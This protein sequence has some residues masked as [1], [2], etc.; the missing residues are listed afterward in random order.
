MSDTTPQIISIPLPGGTLTI[1]AAFVPTVTPAPAPATPK[2]RIGV[3]VPSNEPVSGAAMFQNAALCFGGWYGVNGAQ[4]TSW[5]ANSYPLTVTGGGNPTPEAATWA[6]LHGYPSGVYKVAW[7]GPSGAFR[8]AGKNLANVAGAN[9]QWVADLTLN[10]G[11]Y[12]ELRQTGGVTNVIILSPDADGTT[13]V[14]RKAFLDLLTP[15]AVVRLMPLLHVNGGGGNLPNADWGKRVKPTQWGQAS[16]TTELAWEYCAALCR[17]SKTVPYLNIPYNATDEYI[18]G[19]AGIFKDFPKVHVEYSNEPWNNTGP[20]GPFQGFQFRADG[21]AKAA[22]LNLGTGDLNQLGARY[23]AYLTAHL[24]DVW[25]AA[26]PN[27]KLCTVLGA[28]ATNAA[29]AHD[30]LTWAKANAPGKIGMLA[31]APYVQPDDGFGWTNMADLWAS[32][33]Q[34]ETK[35]V[36]SGMAANAVEAKAYGCDLGVYEGP[37]AVMVPG[38]QAGGMP[39]NRLD[40]GNN[41]SANQLFDAHLSTLAQTDPGMGELHRRNFQLSQDAGV[42]LYCYFMRVGPWGRSGCWGAKMRTSDP[43]NIKGTTLLKWAAANNS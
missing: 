27:Q 13:N 42:S 29:W 17:E 9:G 1:S 23:H 22:A 26:N 6:Q 34:W 36:I 43:E 16:F 39:N 11:E 41:P 3:N 14:Y 7:S 30:A 19:V 10:S 2:M 21:V 20:N 5:D 25:K 33:Q 28:Q 32:C 15:F 4:I 38:S 12:V 40:L 35:Y 8:V 31:V 24:Y 18:T 37:N